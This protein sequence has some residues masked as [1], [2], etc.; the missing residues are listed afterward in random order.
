M[1]DSNV[2]NLT[3]G[4]VYRVNTDHLSAREL[5]DY[6]EFLETVYR[7]QPRQTPTGSGMEQWLRFTQPIPGEAGLRVGVWLFGV[8]FDRV[9]Q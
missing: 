6:L 1:S 4:V 9:I 5:K 2:F 8:T 7:Q 3:I